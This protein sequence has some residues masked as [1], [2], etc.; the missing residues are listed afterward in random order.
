M[1]NQPNEKTLPEVTEGYKIDWKEKLKG[2]LKNSIYKN[3]EVLTVPTEDDLTKIG[4]KNIKF[5]ITFTDDSIREYELGALNVT[6]SNASENEPK[7]KEIDHY[8]GDELTEENLK[9][10][11][12]NLT[13]Q[14]KENEGGY[15]FKVLEYPKDESLKKVSKTTA[16]V[17]IVYGDA[18]FREVEIT[19]NVK[20]KPAPKKDMDVCATKKVYAK[21]EVIYVTLKDE[22]L[23]PMMGLKLFVVDQSGKETEKTDL[24]VTKPHE[25]NSDVKNTLQI[26]KDFFKTNGNYKLKLVQKGYNDKL[27]DINIADRTKTANLST[28]N[29]YV[30]T[31]MDS[32]KI[33]G[34]SGSKLN[35][36]FIKKNFFSEEYFEVPQSE[37]TEQNGVFTVNLKN[38]K[39]KIKDAKEI[40]FYATK[41]NFADSDIV[42]VNYKTPNIFDKNNVNEITIKQNPIKTVY[43][44]EESFDPKGMVVTLKDI[45]GLTKDVKA[46]EFTQEGV[47]V[48]VKTPLTKDTTSVEIS[49]TNAKC[50]LN[51]T[52]NKKEKPA[53]KKELEIKEVKVDTFE[54]E[55]GSVWNWDNIKDKLPKK[56][57]LVLNNGENKE[58]TV[59][60]HEKSY[61]N[62]F[63]SGESEIAGEITLPQ[64]VKG[65]TDITLKVIVKEKKAVEEK[66]IVSFEKIKDFE[67]ENGKAIKTAGEDCEL[68]K[69]F[70]AKL[71]DNSTIDISVK[72][73]RG[74]VNFWH[75]ESVKKTFVLEA[76]YDL[77]QGI[78]G[79]KIKVSLNVIVLPKVVA[80]KP[81]LV[82]DKESYFYTE[83]PVIYLK[84][85]PNGRPTVIFH[86]DTNNTTKD[87]TLQTP[88]DFNWD[89][90]NKIITLKTDAIFKK[91]NKE[92]TKD[93]TLNIT[94]KR[95]DFSTN[96]EVSVDV[97]IHY[98]KTPRVY[99]N[100]TNYEFDNSDVKVSMVFDD[101]SIKN[102]DKVKFFN[103]QDEIKIL[104][105]TN[106]YNDDNGTNDDYFYISKDVISKFFKDS[107]NGIKVVGKCENCKDFFFT[108]TKKGIQNKKITAKA[109]E[110]EEDGT[111]PIQKIPFCPYGQNHSMRIEVSKENGLTKEFLEK[112]LSVKIQSVNENEFYGTFTVSEKN[113]KLI[114]YVPT[115]Q[116]LGK[117]IYKNLSPEETKEGYDGK[118][119]I[120]KLTL[121]IPGFEPNT[122]KFS[123][124]P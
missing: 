18:T 75:N 68:P 81:E 85:F 96:K 6:P 109:I 25:M 102:K 13:D 110:N 105:R 57:T 21:D 120:T 101:E 116:N 36:K 95:T 56:V 33:S 2:A 30:Y 55:Y 10:A 104:K 43:T 61:L 11:I 12:T 37:I 112:N 48:A 24:K 66:K 41:E 77:P 123:V 117:I 69:T 49:Y 3:V 119:P 4:I 76:D 1:V 87:V 52:V 82:L 108:I 51:I 118:F 72:S 9:Q 70:K 84:N 38:I 7:T 113:G 34:E 98:K 20:E 47:I 27:I 83:N 100:P 121:E 90:P 50:T 29:D 31:N 73:W 91:E 15:Y 97:T 58:T 45:N 59:I 115:D 16:K 44:E 54:V 60:W 79:D 14:M 23:H 53:P 122:V 17:R 88:R 107:V 8:I 63:K 94:V 64:G 28:E 46:S 26:E 99:A 65:S 40:T 39:D 106:E 80:P 19:I 89:G 35:V 103:G 42:R 74:N 78:T 92:F 71:S 22:N 93:E 62:T 32:F 86:K 114:V 67:T 111:T 124:Q 5:K